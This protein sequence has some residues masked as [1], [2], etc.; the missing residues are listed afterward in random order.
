MEEEIR[1]ASVPATKM[2]TDKNPTH[3]FP[4]RAF[5]FGIAPSGG[6]R[7]HGKSNGLTITQ[8]GGQ[9]QGIKQADFRGGRSS[10]RGTPLARDSKTALA[11]GCCGTPAT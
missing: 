6:Q 9:T 10:Q 5:H 7:T 1:A 4:E 2:D 11:P 8:F 3:R